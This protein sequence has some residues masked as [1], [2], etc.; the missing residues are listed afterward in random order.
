MET[1]REKLF[2]FCPTKKSP[3]AEQEMNAENV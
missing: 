1:R 2:S 3:K